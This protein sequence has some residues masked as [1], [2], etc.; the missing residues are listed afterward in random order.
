[1]RHIN[2]KKNPLQHSGS[3][4]LYSKEENKYETR[5]DDKHKREKEISWRYNNSNNDTINNCRNNISLLL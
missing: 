2:E 4:V 1:M 5:E 3:K